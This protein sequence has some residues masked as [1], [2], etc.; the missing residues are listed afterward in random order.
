MH[1][2]PQLPF[3]YSA[4]EPYID[5]QTM[6]IHYT[7]HHQ[8]YIDKLNV[9]LESHTDLQAL[10]VEELLG[11]LSSMPESIKMAVRNHGGG[12]AN[13]TLFWSILGLGT[14]EAQAPAL[15]AK[16]VGTFGSLEAFKEKVGLGLFSKRMRLWQFIVPPTKTRRCS[17]PI[18]RL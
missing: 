13:H 6:E 7:K 4:L 5:A 10:S 8:A 2:L 16:I 18:S 3:E 11:K 9:A 1:T 17:K 15:A 14:T 12:H